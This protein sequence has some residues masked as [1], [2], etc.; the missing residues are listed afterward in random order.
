ML[1]LDEDISSKTSHDGD[2][3][4]LVLTED[5]KVGDVVVAK[6]GAKAVGEVTAA[7]KSEMMGKGGELS[8]RLEYLKV[9]N[10]KIHLRGTKAAGGKDSVGGTVGLMMICF[11]CGMLHHG[12]ESKIQKGTAVHAYVAEDTSLSPTI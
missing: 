7:E 4:T 2:P 9:G 3:V 11:V 10:E 12:K 6:A 1:V 5:L 8:M